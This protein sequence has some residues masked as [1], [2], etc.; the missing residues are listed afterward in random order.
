MP[1]R[2]FFESWPLY[3]WM[4]LGRA[5]PRL[6]GLR[7]PT[8]HRTCTSCR[9]ERVFSLDGDYRGGQRT[10]GTTL[11][12]TVLHALYR[13]SSCASEEHHFFFRLSEDFRSI[14]LI[15]QSPEAKTRLEPALERALGEHADLHRKGVDCEAARMGLGALAYFRRLSEALLLPLLDDFRHLVDEPRLDDFDRAFA[16]LR[17]SPSPFSRLESIAPLL[18]ALLRPKRID[19][20]GLLASEV[21][22]APPSDDRSALER[23]GRIRAVLVFLLRQAEKSRSE[24]ESLALDI[25]QILSSPPSADSTVP[26]RM[27]A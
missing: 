14:M 20:L 9:T 11:Q 2:D 25:E 10:F 24:A 15:G 17:E 1:N 4:P 18:P 21:S 6:A 27:S 22:A 5:C 13:C 19:L 16:E 23:A 7:R 26:L 12:G 8:I 3:K